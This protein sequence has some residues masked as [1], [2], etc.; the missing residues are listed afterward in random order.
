MAIILI[1][2]GLLFTGIDIHVV[3]GIE[4]PA[5]Q[6]TGMLGKYELAPSIR[7]FTLTNVLGDHVRID[8]LPDIVGCVLIFIG[9]SMMLRYNKRYLGGMAMTVVM[10]VASVL[11]RTCGFIEQDS[12]LVVWIIVCFFAQVAAEL[13][14][15]YLV[16]YTTVGITNALV[17]RG[18]NTRIL[19]VWWLTVICRTYMAFL[20]FVGHTGVSNIYRWVLIV[21]TLIGSVL[22]IRTRKYVKK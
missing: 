6:V 10:A 2:I 7:T 5:F 17:N 15:E 20:N 13:F 4:Y 19:F 12:S 11:L 9:C 21:A 18:T 22:L 16:L 1:A 8:C 3:S 14:M